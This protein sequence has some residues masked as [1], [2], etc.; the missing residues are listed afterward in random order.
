MS[1]DEFEMNYERSMN[2][3]DE[4]RVNSSIIYYLQNTYREL[5]TI[6]WKKGSEEIEKDFINVKQWLDGTVN[7]SVERN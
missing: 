3:F 4:E 1:T 2:D 7:F 6:I 5:K